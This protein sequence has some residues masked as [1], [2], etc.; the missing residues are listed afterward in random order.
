MVTQ[1]GNGKVRSKLFLFIIIVVFFSRH[2]FLQEINPAKCVS[3]TAG[4]MTLLS[5]LW[6]SVPRVFH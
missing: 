6:D 2:K 1:V 5:D 3:T 4:Q